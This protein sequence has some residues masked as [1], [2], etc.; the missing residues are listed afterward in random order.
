M[1]TCPSLDLGIYLLG[2]APQPGR[3]RQG[4]SP[5]AMARVPCA[6]PS[7]LSWI[8]LCLM[9]SC[10]FRGLALWKPQGLF[11]GRRGPS[12]GRPCPA[13]PEAHQVP[14]R[15]STASEPGRPRTPRQSSLIDGAGVT[16]QR[17]VIRGRAVG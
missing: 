13:L 5:P 7:T 3:P 6:F 17:I 1:A 11:T 15:S 2:S 12:P 10:G 8:S 14:G 9:L 16:A 4:V